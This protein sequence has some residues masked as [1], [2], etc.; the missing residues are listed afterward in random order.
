MKYLLYIGIITILF[1]CSNSEKEQ[2]TTQS[3]DSVNAT[4][5]RNQPVLSKADSLNIA[6]ASNGEFAVF[7]P[8]F[9]RAVL[10]KDTL[11]VLQMTRFPFETRG[12]S[13]TDPVIRFNQDDF[14]R[15]YRLLLSQW[16]GLHVSG[17]Q[18][19]MIRTTTNTASINPTADWA[20][21]SA[22]EFQKV[23]GRWKLAFAYLNEETI[24]KL[25]EGTQTLN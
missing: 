9:R 11:A 21:V 25:Q 10:N 5:V 7:W 12:E 17:K 13:D 24:E 22:M 19:D 6:N 1:S 8:V 16:T 4:P 23:G 15:V 18:L 3:S 14:F 20:R 2:T